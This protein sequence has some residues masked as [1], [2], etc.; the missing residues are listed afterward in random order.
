MKTNSAIPERCVV[1]RGKMLLFEYNT[2]DDYFLNSCNS[3]NFLSTAFFH[4]LK[5]AVIIPLHVQNQGLN[6]KWLYQLQYSIVLH[7][8]MTLLSF[9]SLA[10]H[11]ITNIESVNKFGHVNED[12]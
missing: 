8:I 5:H 1:F 2:L 12:N 6:A 3:F 7:C 10:S 9:L 4:K 11:K